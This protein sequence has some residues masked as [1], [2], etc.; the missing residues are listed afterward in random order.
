M[1]IARSP[2]L[3]IEKS[4]VIG[5]LES[6][7]SRDPDI[8]HDRRMRLVSLARF[9]K[10]VGLYLMLLGLVCSVLI[11]LAPIGIP[12]LVLGWWTHRRGVR[13]VDAVRAGWAEFMGGVAPRGELDGVPYRSYG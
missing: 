7:G 10:L 12:A 11:V 5:Y 1:Q 4:T 13:N 8:L 2:F 9:P 6:A 3:K